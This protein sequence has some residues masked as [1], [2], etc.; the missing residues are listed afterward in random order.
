[1]GLSLASFGV[2]PV[3]IG[4]AGEGLAAFH[5]RDRTDVLVAAFLAGLAWSGAFLV[6]LAALHHTL[7][8]RHDDTAALLSD[9]GFAGGIVNAAVIVLCLFFLL[10]ASFR[11]HDPALSSSL[12]DASALANGCTGYGTAVCVGGF[13]LG[14]R[15]IGFPSWLV[16]LGAGV[17]LHHLA[18]AAS[19]AT[20][21]PW[22]PAGPVSASAPLG[23]TLWVGCVAWVAWLRRDRL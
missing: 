23:M 21:G 1:M 5:G 4:S 20:A 10:L 7:R 8:S 3:S 19:L 15:R 22:S 2:L 16:V 17:G 11:A 13:S 9:V 6:Y 18:S 12:Q 14:L